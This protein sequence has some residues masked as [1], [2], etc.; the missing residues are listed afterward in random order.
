MQVVRVG[1][2]VSYLF[3]ATLVKDEKIGWGKDYPLIGDML[4]VPWEYGNK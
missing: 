1:S 3:Y 4:K 2:H